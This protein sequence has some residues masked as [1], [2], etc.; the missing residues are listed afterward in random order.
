[1]QD[2][3]AYCPRSPESTVLYSVV[4][5]NLETFLA[6]RQGRERPVPGFVE[7]EFRSILDCGVLEKGFL[8]LR[9]EAC[10]KNRLLAF[11]CKNRGF[12][13]SCGGRRM[14][15]TAAHLLDRVIPAGP[16]RQWVLS[17]PYALRFRAAFDSDLMGEVLGIFVRAVF[18]WL[19][20]RAQENGI[21][22]GQC[23][24]MVFDGVFARVDED[25][26]P[27]F[28]PLRPPDTRHV[29]AVAE[30]V[31]VRVA[32]LLERRDGA[33][34]MEEPAMADLYGASITGTV[35]SGPNAGKKLATFGEFRDEGFE[36]RSSRCAMVSG[37]S[38]HAG[39]SIRA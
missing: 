16:V 11:S 1:M 10:G 39:V 34:E 19:K 29:A 5:Q 4:A 31:A 18:T 20:R 28:Y 35:A 12:C 25:E 30:Q 13:N 36:S 33:T 14:A 8:R 23:G 37:F 2:T 24:S 26:P 9:C 17:L 22:K 27:R 38:V 15:D 7:R 21:L 32:A 6:M 3:V